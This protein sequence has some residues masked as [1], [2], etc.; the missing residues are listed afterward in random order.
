M[1]V[2]EQELYS[3][4]R[5]KRG[6]RN[7]YRLDFF[8]NVEVDTVKGG[9][10]DKM[11]LNIDVEEKST[12]SLS[13]GGGYSTTEDYYMV[14]SIAQN[15]LFGRAQRLELKAQLGGRTNYYDLSFTEPWLFDIPLSAGFDIYNLIRDYDDYEKDSLGG[16]IRFSYPVWDYTRLYLT[17]NYDRSEVSNISGRRGIDPGTRGDQYDQQ[18]YD[19]PVLRFPG[20]SV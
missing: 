16:G 7:L 19:Q 2:Y 15:N 6:I 10:D 8:G 12:G 4:R 11:I 20:P 14:A 9:A 3:G 17:Y 5:L 1:R 13:F 18:C